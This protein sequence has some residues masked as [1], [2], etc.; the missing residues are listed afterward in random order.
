MIR[1]QPHLSCQRQSERD[2]FEKRRVAHAAIESLGVA[3]VSRDTVASHHGRTS[4][5]HRLREYDIAPSTEDQQD[6]DARSNTGRKNARWHEN[7][8]TKAAAHVAAAVVAAAISAAPSDH[9]VASAV[10]A[11]ADKA[12]HTLH[13]H[14]FVPKA[15]SR[16]R[17]IL[18]QAFAHSNEAMLF[19][20][21]MMLGQAEARSNQEALRGHPPRQAAVTLDQQAAGAATKP[22]RQTHR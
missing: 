22:R 21:R 12:V 14:R 1:H 6:W 19:R 5:K 7:R 10:V 8:C 4:P 18:D 3:Q 20:P 15:A 9:A 2:L 11:A 13:G 17:T 16:S